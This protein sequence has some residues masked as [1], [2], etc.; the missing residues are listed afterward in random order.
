MRPTKNKPYNGKLFAAI[1]EML[2]DY[3]E[4]LD[5]IKETDKADAARDASNELQEFSKGWEDK[6]NTGNAQQCAEIL[7]SML[8]KWKLSG[9]IWYHRKK[10]RFRLAGDDYQPVHHEE[11]IGVYNDQVSLKMLQ[12]D[13]ELALAWKDAI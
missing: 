13:C 6:L 2:S 5:E 12:E 10:R 8:K 4:I 7:L 1:R 3:A 11:C 9:A